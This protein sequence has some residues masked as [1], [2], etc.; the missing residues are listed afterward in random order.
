MDNKVPIDKK[1]TDKGWKAMKTLLDEEMPVATSGRKR[2]ALWGS[3]LLFLLAGSWAFWMMNT[4]SSD[5]KEEIKVEKPLQAPTKPA[6]PMAD[7]QRLPN[8]K[9]VQSIS[10]TP[11]PESNENT[12]ITPEREEKAGF[13]RPAFIAGTESS[14]FVENQQ[15]RV[16]SL[17]RNSEEG[18]TTDAVADGLKSDDLQLTARVHPL[19]KDIQLLTTNLTSLR[20]SSERALALSDNKKPVEKLLKKDFH[21]WSVRGEVFME[22][23]GGSH[24]WSLGVHRELKPFGNTRFSLL[25]GAAF[26]KRQKIQQAAFE[27]R[28][29]ATS[30]EGYS[31]TVVA[32]MHFEKNAFK[33][34]RIELTKMYYLEVPVS[35]KFR[36]SPRFYVTGGGSFSVLLG[37][38][39]TQAPEPTDLASFP[40]VKAGFSK[41]FRKYDIATAASIGYAI[42]N[43]FDMAM[44][45]EHGLL[46]FYEGNEVKDYQNKIGLSMAVYF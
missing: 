32:D 30:G 31:N 4:K 10:N 20:V 35:L 22:R 37:T 9:P 23:F 7:N 13:K 43:R 40:K 5:K 11:V 14:Q 42:S 19:H 15:Q 18:I 12:A 39:Y 44:I 41:N 38:D 16:V 3:L 2:A 6:L 45:F 25:T 26:A 1:L 17:K 27:T 34:Y 28:E 33:A 21:P 8:Q 36:F 29:D 46:D 24:G